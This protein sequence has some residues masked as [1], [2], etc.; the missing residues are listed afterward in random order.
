[1]RGIRREDDSGCGEGLSGGG[2]YARG[3]IRAGERAVITCA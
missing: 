1:M 3:E 2:E